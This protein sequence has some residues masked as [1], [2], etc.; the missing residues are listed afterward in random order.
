MTRM[1]LQH[2]SIALMIVLAASIVIVGRQLWMRYKGHW[3]L[4]VRYRS[5]AMRAP[6]MDLWPD[7]LAGRPY[8]V[9]KPEDVE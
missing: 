3:Q 7:G 2:W 8:G 6:V 1:T 4:F 5:R 9:M